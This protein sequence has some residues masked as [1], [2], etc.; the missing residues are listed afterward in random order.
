MT[1]DYTPANPLRRGFAGIT[2]CSGSSTT[3]GLA[4]LEVDYVLIKADGLPSIQ[5]N[6]DPLGPPPNPPE[7][8]SISLSANTLTIDYFGGFLQ[9]VSDV[10]GSWSN[11]VNAVSP[12]NV[13]ITGAPHQ[14][15]RLRQ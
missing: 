14:F 8:R 6:F 3:P 12:R 1:W 5:V 7:F 15:Y 11:V 4:H 9:S 10:T 2:G 13:T